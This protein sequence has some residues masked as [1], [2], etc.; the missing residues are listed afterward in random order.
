MADP[1][2]NLST[3]EERIRA[4]FDRGASRSGLLWQLQRVPTSALQAAIRSGSVVHITRSP[5]YRKAI[6]S[7]RERA[8]RAAIPAARRAARQ[9]LREGRITG[10]SVDELVQRIARQNARRLVADFDSKSRSNLRRLIGKIK[11]KHRGRFSARL[12]RELVVDL[13]PHIGMPTKTSIRLEKWQNRAR[14]RG[15][16]PAAMAKE[17]RRRWLSAS[18]QRGFQIGRHGTARLANE[19]RHEVWSAALAAEKL[20]D[21]VFKKAVTAGDDRVREK[22]TRQAAMAPVPLNRRFQLFPDLYPP[23]SGEFGCRCH[24]VL[25]RRRK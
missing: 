4:I 17:R 2:K 23:W 18:R 19:V 7:A 12:M 5:Q 8:I 6:A 21:E 11:R 1:I 10:L 24:Y 15:M 13:R 25:V 16:A 9:A 20:P 3:F 22:H 14:G